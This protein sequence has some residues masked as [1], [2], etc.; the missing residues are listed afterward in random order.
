MVR[1]NAVR[2]GSLET[3]ATSTVLWVLLKVAMRIIQTFTL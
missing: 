1:A 3:I 2:C